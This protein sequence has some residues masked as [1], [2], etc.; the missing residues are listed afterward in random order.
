[1]NLHAYLKGNDGA[2]KGLA[3]FSDVVL[4]LLVVAIVALMILPLPSLLI[5]SL[6]AV[7]ICIGL[8]LVLMGIYISTA[9]QFSS[10]PSV[11][12]IS[13]LFRL[14]LSVATTRSILLEGEAGSIIDTFG[15]MVAGGNLV[16]GLVVFL[17]ITLVQFLV[18]A[19]GA[20]RVAEVGARF[21][22]DAM[23]GK[24]MSIDSDLRSGLID[25]VE[26]RNKRR[27]LELESKLHGS[28]DG[29]MKFV[30]GDA[31]AGIVIIIINLLGGLTIGIFQLGMDASTAMAKYSILTI[32]DG[33]VAQIPAL[34]GAMSAGLIV[35]RATDSESDQNLG[36]SIQKQL[37]SIP[38]VLLVAGGICLAMAMVPG[39]PSAVFFLLGFML[40]VGGGLLV[41]ALRHRMDKLRT[42]SFGSVMEG[43][44]AKVRDIPPA[45]A[46]PVQQAV[47]LL[48]EL[49]RSLGVDGAE[50]IQAEVAECV[51]R[52]QLRSGV[53]M[54][55]VRIFFRR[56]DGGEWMLHAFEVPIVS[57]ELTPDMGFDSILEQ[58]ELALR[59]SSTLFLGIQETGHLMAAAS[60][61]YPDIVKEV[62]RSVPT[63]NIAA[64]LRHL[65]DEEVSIRNVRGILEALVQAAQHEKDTYNL[66][67][68]ARMALARQTCYQ[69]AP[70]NHLRAVAL[71]A[72][73]EDQLMKSI[74]SS[75]G[76]QQLSLDPRL[77]DKLRESLVAAIEKHNPA[78][79]L[80]SVQL[81]RHIRAL[82][83]ERCFNVP[84]LSY[85]ELIPSLK[86]EVL[87]QVVPNETVQLASV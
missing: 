10:F 55:D 67:E 45:H 84:V 27:E 24:Q 80:T 62:L 41:P 7:N 29:A 70:D 40:L 86:L 60:I 44:N 31:I 5:D 15:N 39:F 28:M 56:D 75:G 34:L 48:L 38:R 23:P 16:V 12:L 19:K 43:K 35:T 21:T 33:L 64:V 47:P 66:S 1:M 54:P 57:G 58:I 77:Q 82:I 14:A 11:L 25:K 49:P 13:T 59:R 30:K 9:L 74:R 42:S 2:G 51:N 76:V 8:M 81:R 78:V 36:D 3:Q 50:A 6:V 46:E 61:D 52:Y 20:E 79:L 68:F 26:A 53:A 22:L 17:I 37:T 18:I 73:L 87:H 32:G 69:Y 72:P 83:A 63:Q 65:V 85:N 4:A 71:S